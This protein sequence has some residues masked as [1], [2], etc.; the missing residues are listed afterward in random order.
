MRAG[1]CRCRRVS[2]LVVGVQ[3]G[4]SDA[5]SGVTA[6]PAVGFA[7][8]LLVR[9]AATVLFSETTEV[10]DAIDRLTARASSPLVAQAL[11]REMAWSDLAAGYGHLGN[12]NH[13]EVQLA[14]AA[15]LADA[16]ACGKPDGIL[17]PAEAAARRYLEMGATFVAVGSDLGLLRSGTQALRDRYQV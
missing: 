2:W 5:L 1:V 12:S 7:S 8:D 6:N 10:R 16:K 4:G 13:P 11:L 3:C 9:A 14:I 17:A 15:V